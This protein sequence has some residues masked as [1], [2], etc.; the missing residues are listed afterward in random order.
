[1]IDLNRPKLT[2]NRPLVTFLYFYHKNL[3]IVIEVDQAS[4]RVDLGRSNCNN[5][6]L[7][8]AFCL[9]DSATLSH[10]LPSSISHLFLHLSTSFIKACSLSRAFASLGTGLLEDMGEGVC[11]SGFDCFFCLN[12]RTGHQMGSVFDALWVKYSWP[13]YLQFVVGW[14][15]NRQ[16]LIIGWLI[17][18]LKVKKMGFFHFFQFSSWLGRFFLWLKYMLDCSE[19]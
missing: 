15:K 14:S 17:W 5:G 1:M 8:K 7:P 16:K 12:G 2:C 6:Y 18:R 11:S 10:K 19:S 9:W 13:N 4:I 3:T